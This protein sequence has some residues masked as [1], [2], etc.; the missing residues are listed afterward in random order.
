MVSTIHNNNEY[1]S[2]RITIIGNGWGKSS[3][4]L[5]SKENPR[6]S[7]EIP[8]DF[9][10]YH[11]QLTDNAIE[12]EA[13]FLFDHKNQ[14]EI[15]NNKRT[16][17]DDANKNQLV[18]IES[19]NS[20]DYDDVLN[21]FQNSNDNLPKLIKSNT[22]TSIKTILKKNPTFTVKTVVQNSD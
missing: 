15:L 12:Q 1:K 18:L 8:F 10:S 17:R 11:P 7:Y 13:S 16:E 9:K 5:S 3:T 6:A 4:I 2:S 20:L 19:D 14:D 22:Q 21:S